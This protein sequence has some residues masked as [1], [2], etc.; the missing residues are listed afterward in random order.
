MLDAPQLALP[1]RLIA[2][3]TLLLQCFA[4]LRMEPH[5]RGQHRVAVDIRPLHPTRKVRHGCRV[6]TKRSLIARIG[7]SAN[8]D[9][10]ESGKLQRRE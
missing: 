10:P 3:S 7:T 9:Y 1:D 5:E 4:G 8:T 2:R 6:L